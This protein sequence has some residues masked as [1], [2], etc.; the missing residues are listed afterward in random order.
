M[1]GCAR[2]SEAEYVHFLDMAYG[3]A[4]EA[5][6][7][8][9]LAHRLRFLPEAAHADLANR[10]AETCKVLNGLLRALRPCRPEAGDCGLEPGS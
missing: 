4:R 3:S 1:E 10:A 6:Y 9:R 8:I 7:Q 5:E 2:S